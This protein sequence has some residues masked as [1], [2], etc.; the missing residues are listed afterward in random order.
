[1]DYPVR[2]V[3]LSEAELALSAVGLEELLEEEISTL[4]EWKPEMAWEPEILECLREPGG[5][6]IAAV[7]D[8]ESARI[9]GRALTLRDRIWDL[10]GGIHGPGP[11]A[12]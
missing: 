1:M 8:A 2:R 7:P 11:S 5:F 12:G 6:I 10:R 4:L 9:I 3:E